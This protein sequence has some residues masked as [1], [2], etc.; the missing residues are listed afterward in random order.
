MANWVEL[1]EDLLSLLHSDRVTEPTRHVLIQ[2][3]NTPKRT[4]TFF[5]NDEFAVLQ[6]VCNQLIPQNDR[7][8]SQRID[9]AGGIDERLS[10]NK[11]NGWRYDDMPPDGD[12]YRLGLQGIDQRA[13]KLFGQPFVSLSDEQ[14]QRVLKDVQSMDATDGVW[15]RLPAD[16]FFEEL[17][18]EAVENY[19][20]HPLAQAEINYVGFADAKGWGVY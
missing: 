14:Q 20:S 15:Q 10:Q 2:R 18:A 16:H 9:I 1:M 6:A 12:A 3:L 17:L 8:E 11:S 5:A 7:P 19:Y 4:P 13:E